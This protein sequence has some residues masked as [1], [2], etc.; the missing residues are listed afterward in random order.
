MQTYKHK[1]KLEPIFLMNVLLHLQDYHDIST[2]MQINKKSQECI[3]YLKR[4]PYFTATTDETSNYKILKAQWYFPSLETI[5]IM[6]MEVPES[7]PHRT[8]TVST[9]VLVINFAG[10]QEAW[11]KGNYRV[12]PTTQINFN[13]VFDEE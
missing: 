4:N 3:K 9:S 7:E 10:S 6:S 13:V 2:F 12:D 11:E 5:H 1:T 8:H